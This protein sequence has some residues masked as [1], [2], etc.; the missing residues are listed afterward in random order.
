MIGH[1]VLFVFA[2]IME[3]LEPFTLALL[4]NTIQQGGE[5]Y[6]NRVIL[7]LGIY[8]S[9][10]FFFWIF[11]GPAR[12]MERHTSFHISKKFSEALYTI[13]SRLPLA[14]HKDNH[15]GDVISRVNKATHAL[16]EF[17]DN[18]YTYVNTIAKFIL[19]LGAI[20]YIMPKFGFIAL[21][22]GVGVV[23]II[24]RFDKYLVRNL[25]QV[26]L[27]THRY[28]STL[29]D[30]IT[31]IGTIITLRIEKLTQ[32]EVTKKFLKIFPPYKKNIVVN[33]VK[34]FIVSMGL[35]FLTFAILLIFIFQEY[36]T[37][38]VILIGNLMAL[39]QYT[40]RFVDVFFRLA[41][42]YE[43]L[44]WFSTDVQS[45]APILAAGE[46]YLGDREKPQRIKQWTEIEIKNLHFKYEDE[47]QRVHT[48]KNINLTLNKGAKIALVGES[49]SGKT[50]LMGILRGLY[51]PDRAQLRVDGK[52]F[53]HFESLNDKVTLIP[54]EPEIFENTIEY[55]IT[56][57]VKT[58]RELLE[59]VVTMARFKAVLERLP[60]KYKT[61]IKEKGVNLSG[62]E[63]Q[64]LALARGILAAM[65]SDIVIMDEPTSS[66]DARNEAH[67][68]E[69]IFR[70]FTDKCI[71]SSVHR[72]HLLKQFDRIY[73]FEDG[74]IVANG[75][76]E[77]VLEQSPRF[78][79]LYEK[80]VQ[81]AKVTD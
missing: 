67:I 11:H 3:M 65:N 51:Q 80:Y 32:L 41:W 23:A 30:Y 81:A 71:V 15:S 47:S 8:A 59:K 4:F 44:V 20:L 76:F 72:L 63:K 16:H 56:A 74:Q 26:N 58:S 37:G 69:N 57:G 53:K 36:K 6:L 5:G 13:I 25:E 27:E 55:N 52:L 77:Q 54:Q 49:G 38:Q 19:S 70:E 7:Y 35:A 31:N 50:T 46:R 78:K 66:M 1:Y 73:Y 29:F 64:R 42:Q 45:V 24:F 43:Q 33:E 14:W 17:T 28:E 40:S 79:K 39:F 48:L 10:S 60:S 9:L 34:W 75:T 62:G 12:V 18:T 61:H 22:A 68:Y 2:N 21:F